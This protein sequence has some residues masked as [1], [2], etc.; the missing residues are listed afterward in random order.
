MVPTESEGES[1]ENSYT[2][3]RTV[4]ARAPYGARA[5]EANSVPAH[6]ACTGHGT[7]PGGSRIQ[8]KTEVFCYDTTCAHRGRALVSCRRN[9]AAAPETGPSAIPIY[10]S[11][12][13]PLPRNVIQT[14]L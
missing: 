6:P 1:G 10:D 3:A 13:R 9:L 14:C 5:L 12:A 8:C 11:A 4:G 2:E 7:R